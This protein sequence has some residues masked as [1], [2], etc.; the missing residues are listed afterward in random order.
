MITDE[1]LNALLAPSNQPY[2]GSLDN[3]DPMSRSL[4]LLGQESPALAQQHAAEHGRFLSGMG[5][6]EPPKSPAKAALPPAQ[7]DQ[8]D[9]ADYADVVDMEA[10]DDVL[11]S[12][13]FDPSGRP[14]TVNPDLGVF[15]ARYSLPGYHA[16]EVPFTV[17]HEIRDISSGADV[18]GIP[19]GGLNYVEHGNALPYLDPT[20]RYEPYARPGVGGKAWDPDS[21]LA[22]AEAIFDGHTPTAARNGQPIPFV[23]DPKL[24]ARHSHQAIPG[25]PARQPMFQTSQVASSQNPQRVASSPAMLR[26]PQTPTVYATQRPVPATMRMPSAPAAPYGSGAAHGFGSSESNGFGKYAVLLAAGVALGVAGR[27]LLKKEG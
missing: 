20:G 14:A 6:A 5:A 9:V 2:T 26:A 27:L 12:G 13:I 8:D 18:V 11:G 3:P 7:R 4:A 1:E 23:G 15:E 25:R 22:P 21:T 24:L 10:Q 19:S 17:N 16:R